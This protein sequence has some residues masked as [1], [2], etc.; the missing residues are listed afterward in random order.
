MTL[1]RL[2]FQAAVSAFEAIFPE[3]TLT[4]VVVPHDI[5]AELMA[6]PSRVD[7]PD[8]EPTSFLCQSKR[9][10]RLRGEAELRGPNARERREDAREA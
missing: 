9:L 2:R 5:L 8:E 1:A 7:Q 3:G 4:E 6:T 10:I